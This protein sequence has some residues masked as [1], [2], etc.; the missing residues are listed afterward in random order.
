MVAI[1]EINSG[2]LAIK[3]SPLSCLIFSIIE[4]KLS[5][6]GDLRNVKNVC[7]FLQ[8]CDEHAQLDCYSAANDAPQPFLGADPNL[9]PV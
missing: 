8:K 4:G 6:Y 2:V 9:L 5:L 3:T 1:A 7:F